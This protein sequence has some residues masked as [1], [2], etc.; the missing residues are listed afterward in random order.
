MSEDPELVT[1]TPVSGTNSA[2]IKTA[3]SGVGD[4]YVTVSGSYNGVNVSEGRIKVEVVKNVVVQ[5]SDLPLSDGVY[6]AE[7][8]TSTSVSGMDATD[9]SQGIASR[10]GGLRKR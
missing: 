7:L 4:T 6:H 3:G 5:I 9:L 1:V 10:G 2:E 8:I